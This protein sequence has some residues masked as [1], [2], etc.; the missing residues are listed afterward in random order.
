MSQIPSLF[1]ITI[2]GIKNN[3]LTQLT[4]RCS[5]RDV[6][7]ILDRYPL[8]TR[9]D[10]YLYLREIYFHNRAKEMTI[11]EN[12]YEEYIMYIN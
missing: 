6:H 3:F 4:F 1:P 11:F 7:I 8:Y 12:A 10:I 2:T 5:T 9:Y